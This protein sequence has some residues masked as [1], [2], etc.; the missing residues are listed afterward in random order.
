MVHYSL[1]SSCF[2]IK[3]TSESNDQAIFL[4]LPEELYLGAARDYVM[5]LT[6]DAVGFHHLQDVWL[7]K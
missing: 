7:N 1:K 5:D 3:H 2:T 4:Q 6:L